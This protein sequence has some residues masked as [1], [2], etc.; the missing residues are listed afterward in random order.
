LGYDADITVTT[1][2]TVVEKNSWFVGHVAK[3]ELARG[4]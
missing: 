4:F 3:S 1:P 2:T